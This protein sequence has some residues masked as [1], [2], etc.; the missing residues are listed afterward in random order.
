MAEMITGEAKPPQFSKHDLIALFKERHMRIITGMDW[1]YGHNFAVVTGATDG[2]NCFIFDVIAQPQLE[3][4]QK[5]EVCEVKLKPLAAEIWAD[6]EDPSSIETFHKNGFRMNKWK[7]EKG[8]VRGG[9]DAVRMLLMPTMGKKPRIYFLAKDHGCSMLVARMTTYHWKLDKVGKPTDIP[10]DEDDDECD[11]L[12]YL[13]M[14]NFKLRGKINVGEKADKPQ[15][16][17]LPAPHQYHPNTWMKQVIA[18]HTGEL[19][20]D[21]SADVAVSNDGALKG[22]GRGKFN[23][24]M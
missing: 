2:H 13:V 24:N 14:N 5:L 9:I 6:P 1:G 19:P 4:T 7:K 17:V 8:S 11:A 18:E 10:D 3:I 12:R 20:T 16:N 23:W 15:E 22:S 21:T